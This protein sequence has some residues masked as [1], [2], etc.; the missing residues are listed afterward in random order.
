MHLY[1]GEVDD[2]LP[3][4]LH[5]R[6]ISR[7]D[8]FA[9]QDAILAGAHGWAALVQGRTDEAYALIDGSIRAQKATGAESSL[10]AYLRLLAYA[11]LRRGNPRAGLAHVEEGLAIAERNQDRLFLGQMRRS[12]GELL[13]ACGDESTFDVAEA[14][15]RG[16]LQLAREL[17]VPLFELEAVAGLARFLLYRGRREEARELLAP[18]CERFAGSVEDV[19]LRGVRQLLAAC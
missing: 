6:E 12:H 11:E 1:R 5:G 13:L 15:H 14:A 4:I 17:Q 3:F 7:D 18:V 19:V 10:P 16:D 9:Y 8:G 2:A